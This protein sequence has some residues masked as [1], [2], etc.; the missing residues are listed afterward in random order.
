[1]TAT[2]KSRWLAVLAV[3]ALLGLAGCGDD[4]GSSGSPS[5][6]P[7]ATGGDAADGSDGSEGSDGSSSGTA[8]VGD[9][10]PIAAPDGLVL[11][12]LA[13]AGISMSGQRQLYYA[14]E[15]VDR[16]VA[17]YDAWTSGNG[18]WSKGEVG[19]VV[20]FQRVDSDRIES[21]TI[22]PDHDP[23]AQADGPVVYVLLVSG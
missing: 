20:V 19:D 11:D 5:P 15:D 23:G 2:W 9:D 10:F 7:G 13:D 16:I 12:A 4:G 8:D 17:F 18:E 22:T 21:I 3:S 1:M 6:D 14:N